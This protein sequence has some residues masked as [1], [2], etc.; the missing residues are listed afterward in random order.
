MALVP[1]RLTTPKRIARP[2]LT[3]RAAK[4]GSEWQQYGSRARWWFIA[5]GPRLHEVAG[6][7]AGMGEQIGLASL[8]DH[9]VACWQALAPA[10]SRMR[11]VP[12]EMST[13]ALVELE[14][15]YLLGAGHALGN[16]LIRLVALDLDLQPAIRQAFK[17]EFIPGSA[18]RDDW[19]FLSRA[20]QTLPAITRDTTDLDPLGRLLGELWSAP[21][22]HA[23]EVL[24]G[25]DFHQWRPQTA[26]MSG[27]VR[28][29]FAKELADGS[30]RVT[31]EDREIGRDLPA[32]LAETSWAAARAALTL[33]LDCLDQVEPA[34]D[35]PTRRLTALRRGRD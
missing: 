21:A 27:A 3:E 35:A 9:E 25:E 31:A 5:G 13:R 8:A 26:G 17:T 29:D 23:L 2:A 16:A 1:G 19:V 12:R 7:F 34:L 30:L 10:G 24:R 11:R 6:T 20:A 15:L 14:M 32:K 28:G 22:W 33:L 4:T 18:R